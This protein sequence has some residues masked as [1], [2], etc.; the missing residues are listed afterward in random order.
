LD[1]DAPDTPKKEERVPTRKVRWEK[2][3]VNNPEEWIDN[4]TLEY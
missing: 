4:A 1:A 3:I 2:K